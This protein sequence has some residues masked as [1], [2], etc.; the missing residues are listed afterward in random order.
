VGNA[1]ELGPPAILMPPIYLK[2]DPLAV[3]VG[4]VLL[5]VWY[6]AI[7]LRLWKEPK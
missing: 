7:G 4:G 2:I 5:L 6:A 3:A 1:L